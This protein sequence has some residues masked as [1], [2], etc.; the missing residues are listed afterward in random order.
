MEFK[1][2]ITQHLVKGEDLNHHGTLYA[3]RTAEW[4]VESGFIA[5][6]SLTRP[7][8]IVCMNIH[9]MEFKRPIH[10]GELVCFESQI[11]FAGRSRLVAHIEMKASGETDVTGFITFVHVD[12]EGKSI[13]HGLS[14]EAKTPRE[15]ELQEKAKNLRD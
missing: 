15:I 8:N 11:V 10:L 4:F 12:K 5:A 2:F 7:E 6:A 14:I 3:G 13:P 9:G 1:T